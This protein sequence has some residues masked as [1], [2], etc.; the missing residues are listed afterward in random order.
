[1]NNKII[2]GVIAVVIIGG[3]FYGGMVYGKSATPS[4]GQFTNGQ[5]TANINGARGTGA[6]VG[7]NG[8]FT[9]GEIISKDAT[10]VTIKMQ[11]GSTKIAL[12]ASSTQ[13][14]KSST[15]SLGDL[16]TGVNVN[17]TGTSN[18]DGS[19]TAQSVQIRPAGFTPIGGAR[20]TGQ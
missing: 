13:I 16:A 17:I 5:F 14:M 11:D 6:R 9:A 12:I 3:S 10:S 2:T 20:T 1:M 15:G 8:G 19:I 4:R 7:M 18:S